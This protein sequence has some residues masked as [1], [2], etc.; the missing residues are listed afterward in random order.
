MGA[1]KPIRFL[2]KSTS[3]SSPHHATQTD[4]ESSGSVAPDALALSPAGDSEDARTSKGPTSVG[5]PDDGGSWVS[6]L[7][8]PVHPV[9]VVTGLNWSVSVR[10]P[11]W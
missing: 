8:K 9:G 7:D 5:R 3:C 2:G 4:I 11:C 10:N 1:L 6:S